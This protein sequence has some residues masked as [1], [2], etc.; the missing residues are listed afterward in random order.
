MQPRGQSVMGLLTFMRRALTYWRPY[1]VQAVLIVVAMLLQ[2]A[3]NTF[4]ALSLKLIIDTALAD[5][6]GVLLVRI[7]AALAGGFVV[8]VL[9]NLS[10][11][12]LT[13][14]AGANIL[15]DLRLKMFSHLQR[16]SMDF[17]S[18]AKTGNVVA[19]FSSDLADI[20]K[21]LTS[22][23][24]DAL[25]SLIGLVVNVPLL[26]LLEWRL[27]LV[28]MVAL[29]L[30]ML[31]AR[32]FTPRASRANYQL[33][34]AQGQFAST[35]HEHVRGQPVIKVFGLQ[36][37]A[38]ARFQQQL[39]HLG[40]DTVRANFF[41]LLVG[42]ASSLGVLLV[43]LVA[44]GTGALLALHGRLTVGALVA[45]TSLLSSVNKDAYSLTKKVVPSLIT[46]TGG[47]QRMEDLLAQRPRVVDAPGAQP[48]PRLAREIRFADVTFSYTGDRLHLDHISFT[49]PAGAM[50]AF[51]GPSGAGKS[52]I[53]G[54]LTRFYDVTTG[55]VTIDGHD[56]R[57]IT[58]ASLR[59]QI[60]V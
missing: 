12:Y 58:Q 44:L 3:F 17:F 16:L 30:M 32:A 34:Q 60:G 14:R 57:R 8:A 1:R 21:G 50:A 20:E 38:L 29:P 33:K 5:A 13:A 59:A 19:H 2:Q 52:T 43:Q 54:L 15:N 4:L 28:S 51:V 26:F 49:I 9:A 37:F 6:D 45:F 22:R 47:L 24:S 39:V 10:V 48:L 46:A 41:T 25:L 40:R 11:D 55:A 35:V 18:H 23:L 7:L 36:D 53:L 56:L 42:T 27:A 31:G